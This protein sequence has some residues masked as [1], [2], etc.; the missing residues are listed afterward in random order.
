MCTGL[1]AGC[2]SSS[3]NSGNDRDSTKVIVALDASTEPDSGFD[4]LFGWGCGE[5]VHA[6]FIQ[7]T[8][9]TYDADFTFSNDLA[10]DWEISDDGLTWTF[11]IRNDVKFTNG[12]PLVAQDVAFTVNGVLASAS[13]KVDLSAL[14][15]AEAVD[16]TTVVFHLTR[17]CNTLLFSLAVIGIVP[18]ESYDPIS[19]GT[20]PVG[21]G[22]YKLSKWDRGRRIVLHAN[23]GYYGT[24]PKMKRVVVLLQTQDEA[25]GACYNDTVDVGFTT[26]L[27]SGKTIDG[28]SILDCRTADCFGISLPTQPAGSTQ[29]FAP[30]FSVAAGNA[31]TCDTAVRRAMNYGLDRKKLLKDAIAGYGS[32]AYSPADGLPWEC[33]G[34]RVET[35]VTNAQQMLN[36]AGWTLSDTDGIR[37]KNGQRAEMHLY[38]LQDDSIQDP[39]VEALV[40]WFAGQMA[41]LG[42][43]ISPHAAGFED[44]VGH[45]YTDPVLWE[46][47]NATPADLYD[48]YASDGMVNFTGYGTADIDARLRAADASQDRDEASKLWS[49]ALWNGEDGVA[50][51]GAATWVWLANVDH[52]YYKRAVLDTGIQ[53]IH[54]RSMG[55]SLLS[56]VAQWTWISS[57]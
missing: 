34:M 18:S 31:V 28:F 47:G 36:D 53:Q 1:I 29:H 57:R 44:M 7:S 26:P 35:N 21:S 32:A 52:L 24:P 37:R 4:P 14:S 48:I 16:S 25:Y 9:V 23:E 38:Y 40:N 8:L 33:E 13:V 11:T 19:Y 45:A 41:S 50:P 5:A 17:P 27:S 43:S 49:E 46:V 55:W 22:P 51:Q 2:T 3:Q 10:T 30:G 42:I 15:S 20:D 56:N 12:Q 6:P 39:I 54:T